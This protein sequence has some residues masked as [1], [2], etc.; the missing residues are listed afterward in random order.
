MNSNRRSPLST[1]LPERQVLRRG[2]EIACGAIAAALLVALARPALALS[3]AF[4]APAVSEAGLLDLPDLVLDGVTG[5]LLSGAGSGGYHVRGG[6]PAGFLFGVDVGVAVPIA[7][8]GVES[9][10]SLAL[11]ARVGYQFPNGLSA[12]FCYQDLGLRPD[13]VDGAQLQFA[14]LN[15]RYA[16]PYI[17]PM[18]YIEAMAGL[19]FATT[20]AALGPGQGGTTVGAGGAIG[21]GA[22][23]PLTHNVG[24]DVGI[25][26]WLAP[27]SSQLFQVLSI[28]TGVWFA[29]GA[30]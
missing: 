29:F 20:D 1:V 13:L 22:S 5:R 2:L 25:R 10:V 3:D 12:S 6:P 17:F 19:S 15:V 9:Q 24:I 23:F 16:F 11:G 30:A 27:V 14:T 7:G 21:I 28:E 26:D 4:E 8:S 18:P